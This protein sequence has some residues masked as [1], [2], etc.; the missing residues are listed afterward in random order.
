MVNLLDRLPR[1]RYRHAVVCLTRYTEFRRRMARN[2]VEFHALGKRPGH[3]LMM[4]WRLWKL[5]RAMRPD[6]VHTRNLAALEC[7]FVAA[8]AGVPGR[9]HGEHGRDMFDLD[10]S[11]RKYNVLRRAARPLVHRYVSV[12]RDLESWLTTTVGLPCERVKQI[13]NGVDQLRFRPRATGDLTLWPAGFAPQGSMVF[14]SVGRMVAVKDYPTLV[15]A[16][17]EMCRF[18]PELAE[19]VRL[20]VIGEGESRRPCLELLAQAGLSSRAWLPGERHDVAELMRGMDVFVLPSVGEGISN[21]I[22]EAM[23]SGLPVIATRV[24]GNPE[25]VEDGVNGRLVPAQDATALAAALADYAANPETARAHGLASR[26]DVERRFSLD[27]MVS[28][29]GGVYDHVLARRGG[30]EDLARSNYATA[31]F[32]AKRK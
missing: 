23:A 14:G 32:T 12:S 25:L 7:Q 4:F 1:D 6:I 27:A 21:T 26:C 31:A 2:D 11:N 29:Y 24:G 5:L 28:A 20:V 16:F 13:Y 3:D 22:L 30:R 8:A 19:R 17:I 15:R 18:R 9:V 10:G